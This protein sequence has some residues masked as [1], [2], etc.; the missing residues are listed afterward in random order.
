MYYVNSRWLGGMLINFFIIK[1]RIERMKELEKLDVEGILDIDYIK[2][3]VVEFR[4]ELFKFFKNLFGIRDMEK[5][6][7]VIYV[8]DVK[9]EELLVKEVYLL[10][11][12]VFVMI[13][14]NVDFDLIIYLI[15]VNDDVIR[16]VK[17]IIFVIVNV[18]VEGN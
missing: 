13:D 14:I 17:L 11:I 15:F 6:L 8:V 9:M 2:K 5:V 16:L 1:K 3:E 12:F 10:G 4:K 7:D 18:I